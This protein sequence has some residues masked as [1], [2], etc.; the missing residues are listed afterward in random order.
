MKQ[1]LTRANKFSGSPKIPGDKSIS[2]RGL[3]F[4]S[5]AKGTTEIFDILE[6]EDVQSTARCLKDLGV[7]ISKKNNRTI[8][9][10][11]G[12]HEFVQPV[13][14]LDCGNSGTTMRVLMGVLAGR[15]ITATLMGDQSLTRRPM[16]R[17]SEP[18]RLMGSNFK[19]TNDNFPPLTVVGTKIHGID[20]ELKIASAQI[21]T[22]VM[23]AALSAEGMTRIWGEIASR[24]HTERLLP[25]FGYDLKVDEKEIII[26]GGLSLKAN[27][28]YVP[29]DP[30]T[31]AFWIGAASIIPNA[32]LELNDISLNPTRTGFIQALIRMGASI[33]TEVTSSLPEPIG[34]I[35]VKTAQLKGIS[36]SKAD[37][38]SLIDELPLLA[39]LATQAQG[40]TIVTG[41]EE[42]RVK[43]SDRIEALA[44]N[45]RLMGGVIEVFPDGFKIIGPQTLSGAEIQSYHDH[46]IAMAFS[47]AGLVADGETHIHGSECVSISYPNFFETLKGLT[48]S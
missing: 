24:D 2:H 31:A 20:Y 12:G 37:I 17:V 42:L 46:R 28:L 26:Q 4:G 7:Q 8:V 35:F 18:L 14:D 16:K 27:K 44:E 19:L 36:L 10:G 45:I 1:S 30:S 40:E 21:K 15:G 38:P 9:E 5:L 29:S 25:H 3:I 11:M 23:M 32:T 22:A 47:V 39:V 34:K 43:E 13:R 41:A 48:Q 33:T 6:S